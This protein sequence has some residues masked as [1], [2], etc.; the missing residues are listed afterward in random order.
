MEPRITCNE[1][2]GSCSVVDGY[3]LRHGVAKAQDNTLLA[4]VGIELE[5]IYLLDLIS[6]YPVRLS[7]FRKNEEMIP[8]NT[9]RQTRHRGRI[10]RDPPEK[11]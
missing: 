10:M 2:R 8:T 3:T 1:Y 9:P 7:C 5:A 4:F 11:T 6:N